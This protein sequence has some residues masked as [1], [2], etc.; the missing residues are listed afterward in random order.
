MIGQRALKRTQSCD[1]TASRQQL[2]AAPT[3]YP[4]SLQQVKDQIRL[5]GCEQDA[6]LTDLIPGATELVEKYLGRK[7]ITQQWRAFWDFSTVSGYRWAETIEER[8]SGGP[9]LFRKYIIPGVPLQSV[10]SISINERDDS[11][12]VVATSQYRVDSIDQDLNGRVVL[13]ENGG[14]WPSNPRNI[15]AVQIDYTA[16]YG[17]ATDVPS[18]IRRGLLMVVDWMFNNAGGCGGGSA[19]EDSAAA[20]VLGSYR[21]RKV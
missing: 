4:V 20:A 1:W 12:T 17:E 11:N 10:E 19:I 15:L 8:Y 7:L 6:L 21:M 14:V 3:E 9:G 2:T 13:T 16:G 18:A 5:S